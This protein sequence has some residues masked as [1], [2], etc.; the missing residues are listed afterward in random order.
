MKALCFAGRTFK[1]I[2]R[3]PLTL[4]FGV[5][6]PIALLVLMT[7]IQN[8]A[9]VPIFALDRLAPA[10]AVFSLSFISLYAGMLIARDRSTSFLARLFASPLAAGDYILGYALP[11]FPIAALQSAVCLTTAVLL[12]QKFTPYLFLELLAL[13]PAAALFISF[14]L[15]FG[16]IF[17]DKAVGGV[18][19]ILVNAATLLG[20]TWFDISIMPTGFRRFAGML[21]FVHAVDLARAAA[22]GDLTAIPAPLAWV[23][24]W[25][26]VL[27]AAAVI[28][29]R[30]R[31]RGEGK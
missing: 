18:S 9:P 22:R 11:L 30:Q 13:L 17:S 16:T 2:L 5:G 31:M 19:S 23:L 28:L 8:S 25:S 27:A 3:D 6:L 15:L 14:A 7:V 4:I 20:G 1:E 12:G 29:F 21:P 26:A 10:I 24:G